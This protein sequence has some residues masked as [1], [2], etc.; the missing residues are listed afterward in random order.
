MP[1]CEN[2]GA[3]ISENA[4]FCTECGTPLRR[5]EI[6]PAAVNTWSE[7]YKAA[8]AQPEPSP[9]QQPAAYVPPVQR[10]G[11]MEQPVEAVSEPTPV[12]PEPA[13]P[14]APEPRTAAPR[15]IPVAAPLYAAAP[16]VAEPVPAAAASVSAEVPAAP[17][18][19]VSV[20]QAAAPVSM[21]AAPVSMEEVK[22]RKGMA[23]VAYLGILVFIPL[24][25]ARKEPYARFHT[26]QGLVLWLVNLVCSS[27]SELLMGQ[28]TAISPVL[29]IVVYSV[30][31]V[32]S[33]LLFVLNIV[34]L[35]RAIG[36]VKKPLP[37][38]GG[39]RFLK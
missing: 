38:I 3:Q 30:L 33:V 5:N 18:A 14:L 2:C 24:L 21:A 32:A 19:A 6:K 9:V 13:V 28:L 22:P 34:G 29:T 27:L 17:A 35:C 20:P 4:K 15:E 7:P 12:Q 10:S 1:Y 25:F 31:G 39:I 16:A 11:W 8:P 23:V 37:V 36:G 26:N